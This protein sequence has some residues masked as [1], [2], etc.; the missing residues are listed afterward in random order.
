L[1]SR[2]L[3]PRGRPDGAPR[4]HGKRSA[5]VGGQRIGRARRRSRRRARFG[6]IAA[7]LLVTAVAGT[8]AVVTFQGVLG[9]PALAISAIEIRGARAVGAA[10]ILSTA[11]IR[12]GSS[13]LRLDPRAVVA[14]LEAIPEVRR[15]EVIRELPGRVTIVVEERRPFTLVQAGRLAWIDEDGRLLGEE[16]RAVVPPMPVISGLGE[17]E[18]AS[19]RTTPGP[20]ARAAID[21]IQTL[22]RSGSP[23]AAQVSEIDMSE[24]A[25]PVLY[26]MDGIEVRLGVGEWPDRLARL[27]GVLAQVASHDPTVTAVDLRFR[28]QVVIRRGG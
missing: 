19:M 12:R 26:T 1:V 17:A 9:S 22:L 21:L 15:A 14:R 7:I 3:T 5:L 16:R 18:V 20:R 27:E 2:L 11:G 28:D 24:S 8:A 23:L 6:R 25:G 4:D 13:L 10:R